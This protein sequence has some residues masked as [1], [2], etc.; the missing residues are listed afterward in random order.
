MFATGGAGFSGSQY[1]TLLYLSC[2]YSFISVL[3]SLSQEKLL[4]D[5]KTVMG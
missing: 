1:A 4:K 5:S 3:A 2:I